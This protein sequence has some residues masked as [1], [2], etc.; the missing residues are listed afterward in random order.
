ML[1]AVWDEEGRVGRREVSQRLQG[2]GCGGDGRAGRQRVLSVIR[3]VS[4]AHDELAGG[5]PV[6]DGVGV[7]QNAGGV[8]TWRGQSSS[9]I[10]PTLQKK[11]E[12]QQHKT[13]KCSAA[14]PVPSCL[15]LAANGVRLCFRFTVY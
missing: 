12:H 4:R 5:W 2:V 7:I 6:G 10:T 8:G 15:Q 14:E 11:V 3:A 1:R 13:S 9:C